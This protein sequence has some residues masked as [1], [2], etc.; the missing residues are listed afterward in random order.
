[1]KKLGIIT[2]GGDCGGL[3]AVLK[4]TAQ[5]AHSNGISCYVIPNGYAGLYNL[6]EFDNIVELTLDR[7]DSVNANAAGSEAGHSRVKIKNIK[8]EKKYERIK[9]GMKKFKLDGLVIS[10]GDDSGSVMVDLSENGIKCIHAPKTMDLDLQT[11]SVGFDSTVNRIATFAEDLKTTGRTH[12]RIIVMECFGRYAGHTVFRSG[13]AADADAILIPE[14]PV[15]FD[16]L[17]ED[18]KETF[19][20]RVMIS[21]VRAGTYLILVAEGLRNANG[22][23]LYDEASG[24]DSFGHK[25]L[26]GAGKYVQKELEK[27]FKGDET[28][29]QFMKDSKMYVKGLYEAPEV[30]TVTPGHLVRCG[31]SSVYDV[32]FGKE[33]GAGAVVLLMNGLSGYTVSGISDGKIQYLDAKKA[34]EQRHVDLKMVSFFEQMGACFGRKVEKVQPGFE[35]V[36]GKIHRYLSL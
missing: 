12:N 29:I 6:I 5:M 36:K 7:V 8:D 13:I 3:N 15:D 11:Y 1:M 14:V 9:Q 33:V 20:H 18:C 22:E 30:R 16:A 23:E 19:M 27:R 21:D 34:I 31:H 4:G 25:K 32:N 17:Y 24:V 28:I 35:E 2:S 26:A 10:G